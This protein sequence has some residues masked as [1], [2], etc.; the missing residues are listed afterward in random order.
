MQWRLAILTNFVRANFLSFDWLVSKWSRCQLTSFHEKMKRIV[1][2]FLDSNSLSKIPN[3][4][5]WQRRT[6]T[7]PTRTNFQ[8]VGILV[9]ETLSRKRM[10]GHP[11]CPK[12]RTFSFSVDN[13]YLQNFVVILMTPSICP[14]TTPPLFRIIGHS[15]TYAIDINKTRSI[16]MTRLSPSLLLLALLLL[17]CASCN[18]GKLKYRSESNGESKDD[19]RLSHEQFLLEEG[20][21]NRDASKF[22]PNCV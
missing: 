8:H 10:S 7:K 19:R 15:N 11:G 16:T 21:L 3:I 9:S 1:I 2:Q 5:S 13:I 4:F 14:H 18:H 20:N 22:S 17:L 6:S 12:F